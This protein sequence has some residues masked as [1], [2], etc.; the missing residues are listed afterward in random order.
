M[1]NVSPREDGSASLRPTATLRRGAMKKGGMLGAYGIA[2]MAPAIATLFVMG[3]IVGAA[4]V[5]APLI[6][7]WA[8]IAYL[9]HVNTSAEFNRTTPSSGSYVTFLGRSLG[10]VGGGM[11]GVGMAV[12]LPLLGAAV[13]YQMGLWTQEAVSGLF[14]F[15]LPWWIPGL[16]LAGL[17]ATLVIGGV[18]LSVRAAVALFTFEV[19][20]LVAGMIGMLVANSGSISGRGFNPAN[21]HGGFGH[22]LGLAFP[23]A[24]F[25]FFGA[26]APNTLA[27][28]TN[29]PRRL[30]P[31]AIFGAAI[32]GTI[33]YVLTS[34]SEGI[35]FK[36]NIAALLKAP[37]PFLA[38]A[39]HATPWLGD[40]VFIA[41]FTSAL[42]VLIVEINLSSRIWFSMAR[43]G[44]LPHP[45]AMIHH[46]MRTP[47]VSVAA[48]ISISLGICFIWDWITGPDN[49]FSEVAS[50]G[51]IIYVLIYIAANTA[52]PFHVIRSHRSMY[53]PW[54]H[55]VIPTIGTL[56]F[57]YPLWSIVKPTQPRPYNWFGLVVLV[58]AVG[59]FLYSLALRRRGVTVGTVLAATDDEDEG[60]A[61]E[62][63]AVVG[64]KTE[65][66]SSS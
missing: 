64:P 50:L 42:A 1:E 57:L 6:V 37:Y 61:A 34:W 28:E 25:L 8:G 9:F 14:N 58:L 35:G 52:L 65:K 40:L 22:G 12:A 36:N 55:V 4:G 47:W 33:L 49:G 15:A 63:V 32:F 46:R 24:I 62:K 16:V 38:A 60:A 66:G 29:R 56:L 13:I 54:R 17:A 30:L 19:F 18:V 7:L 48:Y 59:A 20:V 53:S 26:S 44:L 10:P 39:Q 5:A 21:I 11:T 41:G 23:L 3:S 31:R 2:T 43:D 51:S 27:E 45:L